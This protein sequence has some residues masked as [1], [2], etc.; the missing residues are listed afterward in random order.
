MFKSFSCAVKA[1]S[2]LLIIA[3]LVACGGA[4]ERK[5]KY[6]SKS[7]AYLEAKDY[8]KARIEAKNVLQIDPKNVE[9]YYIVGKIHEA[10]NQF[11]KAMGEV[12]SKYGYTLADL[13]F[14]LQPL[15]LG[16]ACHWEC[17][18]YYDSGSQAEVDTVRKLYAEAAEVLL[19]MGVL[20]TR[21]Y[22]ILADPVYSRAAS[23]TIALKKL[24]GLLDPNNIMSPGKLCF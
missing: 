20:F 19:N 7:R 17:N 22:G 16:R 8:D 4:E 12:A 6:L 11:V 13:G 23:Y 5:E 15:E 9:A 10:N 24:K 1:F 3:S 2:S 18:L 21:P 14:Y